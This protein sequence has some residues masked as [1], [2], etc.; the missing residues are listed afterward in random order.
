MTSV[1]RSTIDAV[2]RRMHSLASAADTSGD[3]V[4]SKDEL[5]VAK[6]RLPSARERSLLASAVN[7]A[8]RYDRGRASIP[9]IALELRAASDRL[10]AADRNG[11]EAVEWDEAFTP[12]GTSRVGAMAGK[13]YR[14][15]ANDAAA[16]GSQQGDV[17]DG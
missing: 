15:A 6:K 3:G 11:N 5:R 4:L 8:S 13:L 16:L 2:V 17:V 1:N 7:G 14:V 12:A 10:M 9:A